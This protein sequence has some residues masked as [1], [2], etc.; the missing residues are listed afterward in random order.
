M[1]TPVLTR[2]YDNGR[3]GANTTETVL[4]PALIASK[5]LKR[6]RSFEL[7][8]GGFK[9]DPRLEAQPLY[10]PGIKMPDGNTHDVLFVASMGNFIWAFDVNGNSFW[11][12]PQLGT[13]YKP[14]HDPHGNSP[15]ATVIDS[16]GINILWGILATPVIDLDAKPNPQMYFVNWRL[17]N[18]G[19]PA[20][21]AHRID[22]TT[23]QPVG[24]PVAVA[25]SHPGPGP[26]GNAA[27][28]H[29][30]Q[31]VRAAMLLV[32]LR[33][34]KKTLFFST[35]GGEKEGAPHG[36]M[37][38]ID[39]DT[40]TQTAAWVSTPSSFGGGMWHA[41]Q[42]P[43]ADANGN[44]YAI[45]ANGGF[46]QDHKNNIVDF[47]GKT[48]FAEAI[49][50]LKY[51]K[52]GGTASLTLD[53]WYIPFRDSDRKTDANYDYRD[54]DLGSAAPVLPLDNNLVFASGKDGILY[55]LD[56]N[57]LGKKIADPSVL[58]SPPIYITYNGIGL[59]SAVPS[60]SP[61]GL[62]HPPDFNLGQPGDNPEK[63]H[64]LHGSP[65]YWNGSAGPMLFTWG[66]NESLRAW[67]VDTT[68]GGVTF[69]GRGAEVASAALA[70][71]PT[72]IGGMPGGMICLTSNGQTPNTGI[73]W[74]LAPID[75]DANHAVV[76]GIARAY[77]ATNLDP[78][79][80]DPFTPRLKLLWDSKS[81]GITFNH[82]KFCTPMVAD[83]R[84]FVPTY[85]GQ[86][87]MYIPNP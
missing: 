38:A 61:A 78:T 13:P 41:S 68:T 24:Q 32:P 66:E 20:L 40:F 50:R 59:P 64:H 6:T 55:V 76:E 3:T 82:S 56:R 28:L 81:L 86:V 45:T 73:V 30:D 26:G 5:G 29:P 1:A 35:T 7:R 48:D 80:K 84:L 63:T 51:T 60:A 36:W 8:D 65:V 33:G 71:A 18:T 44:V 34:S 12:T 15:T 31:K 49:V 14:A 25:A 58:K 54:Q 70:F 62:P 47:N 19:K 37:V 74:A 39:V 10:V 27:T 57:H 42:G 77:D 53:D 85:D 69:V 11:R 83:G 79:P 72:G 4:T 46:H 75:Q 67:K 52:T 2:S 87:D 9:D 16:W 17:Q 22:I 21:F 23:M 43:A